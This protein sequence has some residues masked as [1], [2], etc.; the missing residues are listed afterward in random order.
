M[1]SRHVS[2]RKSH[3]TIILKDDEE[4]E[5]DSLVDFTIILGRDF[6]GRYVR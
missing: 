3:T 5:A 6:D 1:D 2:E 4:L